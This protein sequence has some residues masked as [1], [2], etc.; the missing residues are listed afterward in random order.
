M[1]E[2]LRNFGKRL[3]DVSIDSL[4]IEQDL[5]GNIGG[6]PTWTGDHTFE[7]D[8]ID[9]NTGS[10]IHRFSASSESFGRVEWVG[11]DTDYWRLRFRPQNDFLEFEDQ[12]GSTGLRFNNEGPVQVRNADLRLDTGQDIEDGDGSRR[13]RL[14]SFGTAMFTPDDLIAFQGSTDN[15]EINAHENRDVRIYDREGTFQALTYTTS[16]SAPGTFELTNATLDA[17]GNDIINVR[18]SGDSPVVSG[19]DY[20][21]QKDGTDGNGIINFKTS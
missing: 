18:S 15:I 16:T 21:I 3:G 17:N 12:V 20:E 9:H 5:I 1:P 10:P 11:G 8:V 4:T 7:S 13:F 19:A 2:D 14:S 6:T